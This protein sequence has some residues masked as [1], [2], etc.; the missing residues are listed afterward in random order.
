MGHNDQ[1]L[2]WIKVK[3]TIILIAKTIFLQQKK[4]QNGDQTLTVLSDYVCKW[5]YLYYSE[6]YEL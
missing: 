3:I 2:I 1:K 4:K 5:L 6:K